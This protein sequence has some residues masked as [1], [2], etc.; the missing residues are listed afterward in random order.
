MQHNRANDLAS[1]FGVMLKSSLLVV[2]LL[3]ISSCGVKNGNEFLDVPENIADAS[4]NSVGDGPLGEIPDL[5]LAD[6]SVRDRPHIDQSLG[7]N[8]IR[9]D[10]NTALRGVSLSLDG[11]DPYGSL[12][13]NVPTAAQMNLLVNEYGFNT[14]HV[15]LE[16][17][18]EQNPEPVGVNEALADQLV[19]LTREAKMYLIITMGNNGENGAIHSME[20]TLDFWNLYAA[21]YADETHVIFE[22]HNEPVTGING[23]WTSED[24]V[25]QADMYQ[26]IRSAAPDSMVLLGSFMSFFGGSQAISGADG[27]AEQFPGIWENAGFAFHAYWDIA[28]VESTID[29]FE[30]STKY[31]ALLCTEFYPGDTK[32][33]FNE[34]FESHHIGWTQFEWLAANDLELDRFKGYLDAFGTAWRPENATATW[35]ASGSPTIAF[36]E[37]IGL[38]SRADEAFLRLDEYYQIIA[39]DRDYDGVGDDEFV[40]I[41][42]GNDGSVALR[43]SNGKYLTVID[44]GQVL[45]ATGNKI[46]IDQKFQWLEL[47][48]GDIALRPWSGS[49]HLIGTLPVTEGESYG[50]TGPVGAGVERNGANTYRV[51]TS[52]TSSVEPLEEEAE[53]PPGPF[54][55][56]PMPVPTNGNGDHPF[57][58]LS[59]NG[60]IWASDYDYGGEGVAYHDTGAINLGEAYRADEAVDV[61]SSSEGYTAVGFFDKGEWLEYTI[62]VATAGNYVITMRTAS[63]SGVGGFISF[64]SDC[65]KLTG[66]LAT[67]NTNGWDIWEDT[68]VDVTLKAGVQKLRVVSGGDMNLMNFD[69]QLGGEGGSDYGA[70]CEWRPPEPDDIKVEAENWTTVI[71]SPEGTVSIGASTDSDLSDHVGNFDAEDFIE[72]AVDVPASGCYAADYRIA[73]EPGSAGFDLSFGGTLVD[74][75]AV[76]PTGGWSSW[77]TF[78]RPVELVEGA[79]TM[80]IDALGDSFNLNWLAFNQTDDAYCLDDG[81]ITIE[82]ET[83]I[84]SIQLPEGEVGTQGTEDEGGGLNVGWVDAGDWMEYEIIIPAA[85]NYELSYRAASQGG[86]NPGVSIYLDGALVDSTAVPDTGGWQTWETVTGGIVELA[87]GDYT[88]RVS[89]LS[90]GFNLNWLKFTPTTE[91][92]TGDIGTGSDSVLNI[93]EIVSFNDP[94]VDYGVVDFGNNISTLSADPTD[95]ANT[96]VAS[97]KG[98]ETW[99]GTTMA[100]GNIIYPLTDTLTRISIR[101]Y[102][103]SE[104]TPVRVKLEESGDDSHSVETEMLTTV[105]NQ[106]EVIIFDF[107]NPVTG[108]PALDTS[109]TF[110][111][112]SVFFD[113]GSA[114]NGETYYWDDVTFLDEYVAP[115]TLTQAILVGDWTLAPEYGAMSVGPEPGSTAYWVSDSDT[116]TARAC[117]FDDLFSFAEDGTFTNV[118]GDQTWVETWQGVEAE[119]C[120]TPV[121]PHDGSGSFSYVLEPD[122]ATIT[123]S[124][125]G[126]HIGLPKVVSGAGELADPAD[127][128]ESV[129][130][131]V[132]ANSQDTMTVQVAYSGGYW[133]FKLVRAGTAQPPEA[134]TNS[135]FSLATDGMLEA[136]GTSIGNTPG[137]ANGVVNTAEGSSLSFHGDNLSG[138]ESWKLN[139]GEWYGGSDGNFGMTLGMMVFQIPNFGDIANPFLSA[140]FEVTLEQKSDALD[141]PADLWAVRAS[142]SQDL[143]LSDW[144]IGPASSAPDNGAAGTL[145]QDSFLMPSTDTGQITTSVSANSQLL[146]Y[147]NA[148]YD[149]GNG[150]G[151]YVFFRVNKADEDAFALGWNAYILK[152]SQTDE[153]E[154]TA[155]EIKYTS[156]VEPMPMPE[157][158][159]EPTPEPPVVSGDNLIANPGFDDT[160]D[161]TAINHYE[162]ENTMGAVTIADGVATFAETEAAEE[163]SWKHMGIYTS[164]SLTPG[165]YQ[166]DMDMTYADISDAWGEAFIGLAEPIAGVEYNGDQQVLKAF[167]SWECAAV[168]TYSGSARATGCDPSANPGQFTITTAGS[169]YLL[170]RSGGASYG[171]VG[172]VIDNLSLTVV[173]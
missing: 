38:Y 102:S 95:S 100:R 163:G 112:L 134:G 142:D 66:N 91:E 162:A 78:K 169:Y 150:I 14:L 105:A 88:L 109:Y 128:P 79:Q 68:T 21:K 124:G 165:T 17:D 37:T 143:L 132:V 32:K 146:A 137:A 2:S 139:V 155:P 111:T 107:S 87:A 50:L 118:M 22:A 72:Y 18:A 117:L 127:A 94:I 36:D 136:R 120:A 83:Y 122:T 29:A 156:S 121:A 56:S 12:P 85:G 131:Q 55:G 84:S 4:D 26:T 168:K 7:Y 34:I 148:R 161:W 8:V 13:S 92:S 154:Q 19:V 20:K 58:S 144:F 71:A 114:G 40:V 108:T 123:L 15:Y 39:D 135:M 97:I 173:D 62:D 24:W 164:I 110:D 46:G 158:E 93:G 57:D 166:F 3:M 113:F 61:Q 49:A 116:V 9:T 119:G 33:G 126:A 47:P 160:T 138:N 103:P 167:N 152:S 44:Y 104:G 69:I 74:T 30:T 153:G 52:Y 80:R 76:P 151:N 70:G 25:K 147:L 90:G 82:A 115:I 96:V 65:V 171:S 140:E 172:I 149:G 35:P 145:I 106:W 45:V 11:G 77:V 23:N 43:A 1:A 98:S 170:F 42:A 63:G 31:P 54:F 81:A 10:L 59:P 48:T 5:T 60:R 86:S 16:G 75:F 51:V 130:Y 129:A 89:T 125:V 99:A 53:I 133:T 141:F 101:I 159:T 67:P 64:E 41:D 73:S 157:P 6:V 27:L 28:Q